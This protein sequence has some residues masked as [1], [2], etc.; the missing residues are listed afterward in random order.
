MDY[1]IVVFKTGL[2]DSC[3]SSAELWHSGLEQP[4]ETQL[5]AALDSKRVGNLKDHLKGFKLKEGR[6]MLDVRGS[7]LL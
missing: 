5:R 6:F 3:P 1:S 7:Y 4:C 2:C